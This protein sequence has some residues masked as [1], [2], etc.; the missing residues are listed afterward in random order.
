MTDSEIVKAL[1][2]W[3][4]NYEGTYG[5][6]RTLGLALDLINRQKAEIENITEK[7]N[8]QQ[9]VYADLSKIIRDKNAEIERLKGVLPEKSG[10]FTV[11][12]NAVVYTKSTE[13]FDLFLSKVFAEAYKECIEKVNEIITEIYNK[14]IFGSNDLTDEEKDS[15]INFSDDVT[16]SIDN[17]LKELAGDSSAKEKQ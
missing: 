10:V 15:V 12:E 5:N 16:S 8:C 1:E 3:I 4:K 11:L 17:L 14:H 7:F 13:E 9:T 6:F 2:N